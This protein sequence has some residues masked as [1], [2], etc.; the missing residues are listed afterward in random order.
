MF[1][2]YFWKSTLERAVKSFA[3]SLLAILSVGQ[4]GVLDVAWRSALSMA[5]MTAVLSAL[6]SIASVR[7]GMPDDPSLVKPDE[8]S[9]AVQPRHLAVPA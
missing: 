7:V 9:A 1:T 4:V 3:Q 8:D 6:T 5:A 2:A